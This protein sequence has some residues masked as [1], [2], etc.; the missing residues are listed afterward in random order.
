MLTPSGA[1]AEEGGWLVR[2]IQ[3]NFARLREESDGRFFVRSGRRW[4]ATSLFLALLAVEVADL[5]FALDSVPAVLAITRDPFIAYSSNIFA[6]LGLRAMYFGI[7]AM[8]PRFCY[9]HQ[10]LAAILFFVGGKMM[11]SERF[12]VSEIT[13]LSIVAAILAIA[14]AASWLRSKNTRVAR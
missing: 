8:L 10:A 1:T 7:A 12:P 6:I 3:Q 2:F 5:V 13:S 4:R 14:F 9:L 11:F